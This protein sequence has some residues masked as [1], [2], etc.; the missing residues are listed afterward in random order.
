MTSVSAATSLYVATGTDGLSQLAAQ[1]AQIRAR[2]NILQAQTST[3]LVS[4]SY[5][6]LGTGIAT[7][8][9]LA[10]AIAHQAAW[11]AN[12][13]AADGA[14][15]AAGTALAQMSSIASNFYAQTNNLNGLNPSTVDSIAA[16]ARDA[17][18][19][20]AGLLDTK[21]G[22][23]YV[24]AG[25]DGSNPPV[26]NPDDITS[27]GFMTQ[28]GAAVASLAANGAAATAASTLA[29][30][31]STAVGTSPFST[32]LSQ[33]AAALAGLKT[34][35]QV[36]EGQ[37]VQTGILASANDVATSAGT[38]TTGAY[39]RDIMRALATLG[40]LSS[41]QVNTAGFADLV[42]DTRA[43]LGNAIT[44]LNVDAGI[45]GDRQ[46]QL[47][48]TK[49][50]LSD[51]TTALKSQLSDAQDV[52]VAETLTKLTA[53]Q[54]QLQASYQIISSMQSLSLVKFL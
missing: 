33:S 40:S 7:S 48:T 18:R 47:A 16:S 14:M 11:S 10:P 26:P 45:M 6:G 38:S 53:A 54:T 31:S 17:L 41:S 4:T 9:A 34:S 29:T 30:A 25:Q 44:A 19:Q 1:S 13:D 28:I 22:S 8:L 42:Q 35:I 27:S 3:G 15:T 52:D 37:S 2:L 36:G 49:T 5:A 39:T 51:M 46:S 32:A 50:Q 23:T 12:I 21:V 20:F 24:F 43:S